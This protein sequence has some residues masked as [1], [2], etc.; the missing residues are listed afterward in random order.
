M[1]AHFRSQQSKPVPQTTKIQNGGLPS[2][3]SRWPQIDLF[4]TRFNNKL[5]Q[6]VSP[7]TNP[8]AWA[9]DTLSLPWE[10]LDA[11]AF[12][13]VALVAILGKVVEKLQDHPCHKMIAPGCP[14]MLW[15]W[16][17]VTMSSQIPSA[18]PICPTF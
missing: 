5:P 14:N 2:I 16:D 3:C 18:C 10:D 6:F 8:L 15:F 4:A 9:V 7:V 17:L 12:P 11:Y 1:E 13:L